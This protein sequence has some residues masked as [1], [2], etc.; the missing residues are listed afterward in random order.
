MSR[1]VTAGGPGG[2]E[3]VH[4]SVTKWHIGEVLWGKKSVTYSVNGPQLFLMIINCYLSF[5]N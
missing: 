2:Q 3:G 1:H 5:S 4:A